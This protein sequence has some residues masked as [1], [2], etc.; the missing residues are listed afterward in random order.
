MSLLKKKAKEK[1]KRRNRFKKFLETSPCRWCDK[2]KTGSCHPDLMTAQLH[3]RN[4]DV[5]QKLVSNQGRILGR[6]RTASCARAQRQMKR[7]IK[8]ARYMGLM[9]YTN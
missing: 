9:P 3:Y 6:R 7:A 8:L 5:L 1:R 2:A 4:V